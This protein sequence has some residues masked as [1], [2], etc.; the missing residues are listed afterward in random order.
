MFA[1]P[2]CL[3]HI[4]SERTSK[5]VSTSSG[6]EALTPERQTRRTTPGCP[7]SRLAARACG[8]VF[9]FLLTAAWKAPCAAQELGSSLLSGVEH[10]RGHASSSHF[11]K[12]SGAQASRGA[13]VGG[14]HSPVGVGAVPVD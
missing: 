10:S 8:A 2:R 9:V 3:I 13:L 4:G 6:S 14:G 5:V 12:S 7:D 11:R 1:P